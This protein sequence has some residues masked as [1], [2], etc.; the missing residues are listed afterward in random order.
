LT[1][2]RIDAGA[3]FFRDTKHQFTS[4]LKV[5]TK[6]SESAATEYGVAVAT[7]SSKLRSL[8]EAKAKAEMV[9]VEHVADAVKELG[10]DTADALKMVSDWIKRFAFVLGGL[11]IAQGVSIFHQG[12]RIDR[13]SVVWFCLLLAFTLILGFFAAGLDFPKFRSLLL[14][15]KRRKRCPVCGGKNNP[16]Q[17][18]SPPTA[19]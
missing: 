3:K 7:Y 17:D 14:E 4:H 5:D 18:A 15:R 13:G 6:Y 2:A 12:E 11:T 19:A 9:L 1:E 10:G 8:A 16:V